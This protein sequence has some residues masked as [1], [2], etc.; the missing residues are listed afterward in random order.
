MSVKIV[1]IDQKRAGSFRDVVN[2]LTDDINSVFQIELSG[3]F[4]TGAPGFQGIG[5]LKWLRVSGINNHCIVTSTRSLTDLLHYDPKFAILASKGT[6]F[7]DL[8][9]ENIPNVDE[10][11]NLVR[12]DPDQ[13]KQLLRLDLDLKAIRHDE[14]N[15]YGLHQLRKHHL[16]IEPTTTFV[17][18]ENDDDITHE[19]VRFVFAN[20]SGWRPSSHQ[21]S[22]AKNRLISLR[23]IP[24]K[25]IIF[26]DDKADKGWGDF[27][28]VLLG[29]CSF[30][31]VVPAATTTALTLS[32]E[33]LKF[34]QN[35]GRLWKDFVNGSHLYIS[36]LKLLETERQTTDY[37]NLLSYRTVKK[38]RTG[39]YNSIDDRLRVMYFTASN[40]LSKVKGMLDDRA[41]NP[42]LIF[43]KEGA[44]QLLTMEQSFDKYL[45][46]LDSLHILL[47]PRPKK[48]M[49]ENLQILNLEEEK[50]KQTLADNL[51]R[52]YKGEIERHT[53]MTA[54]DPTIGASKVYVDTNMFLEDKFA[55][56]LIELM[57]TQKEKIRIPATV[58]HELLCIGDN[59]EE[60]RGT[61]EIN[62]AFFGQIIDELK[63]EIVDSC[64]TSQQRKIVEENCCNYKW[65]FADDQIVALMASTT[66]QTLLLTND[67]GLTQLVSELNS[68]C[69]TITRDIP[70]SLNGNTRVTLP[71]R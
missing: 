6:T 15:T 39:P 23:S 42:H 21:I 10:A 61:I 9:F 43:T 55:K 14:A 5:L 68:R 49:L 64:L 37:K 32:N 59:W 25:T 66:D 56:R 27:L 44:D 7:V 70:N 30:K 3:M 33:V 35:G 41:F 34:I 50:K 13:I 20:V 11:T 2:G 28:R 16:E 36:D 54:S 8:R 58:R 19:I 4:T 17:P 46:L 29:S 12:A 22:N 71:R 18:L 67:R 60:K 24:N 69:V 45:E 40:D 63:I 48:K 52:M 38:L 53:K 1:E 31:Q 51:I 26:V 47:S 62:A 57:V 65:D